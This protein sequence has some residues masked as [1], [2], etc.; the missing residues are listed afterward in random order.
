MLVKQPYVLGGLFK[1]I[2]ERRGGGTDSGVDIFLC[3][4]KLGDIE[5]GTVALPCI[6]NQC[7]V[8]SIADATDYLPDTGA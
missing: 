5:F 7:L 1:R 6:V 8:A 4:F 2:H 3:D